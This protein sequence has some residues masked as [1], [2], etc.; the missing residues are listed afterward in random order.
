MRSL[1]LL[2]AV[3]MGALSTLS[4]QEEEEMC[5]HFISP[6]FFYRIH[7]E[8]GYDYKMTGLGFEYRYVQPK[9]VNLTASLITNIS[10][11]TPLIEDEINMSYHF[12][13]D[14]S[15]VLYPLLAY[16]F[17][18]HRTDKRNSI[19]Y[20][21]SKGITYA[22]LG[23]KAEV[24]P[25]LELFMEF[26]GF[27][28]VCNLAM[29]KL[30]N[31]IYGQHYSNPHGLRGKLGIQYIIFPNAMVSLEGNYAKTFPKAYWEAGAQLAANVGF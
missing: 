3:T 24:A 31:H 26:M 16:R 10:N 27:K 22:G 18:S 5:K 29:A 2:S 21:I 7:D 1:L 8:P 15:F 9:G 14:K 13:V 17:G 23:A 12:P 25:G 11:K 30:D 20:F 4:A 6:K 19:E 28:D